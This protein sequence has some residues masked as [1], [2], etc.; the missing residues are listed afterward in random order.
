MR[1]RVIREM[2]GHVRKLV[3][4]RNAAEVLD[5]AFSAY[6]TSAE[7][8]ALAEEFY[9]P[10]YTVFKTDDAT[11]RSLRDM[12]AD[13]PTRKPSIMKHLLESLQQ[14]V[15]KGA[16]GH[17]IVHRALLDFMEN[18]DDAQVSVRCDGQWAAVCERHTDML[19]RTQEMLATLSEGWFVQVLHTHDG[20]R[21]AMHCLWRGTAKDRRAMMKS[22]KGHVPKICGDD[23][24]HWSLMAL[25]DCVDDTVLVRKYILAPM[26]DD[27][28]AL[29]QNRYARKVF[30]YLVVPRSSRYFSP[31]MVKVLEQGDGNANSKKDTDVRR[32][33]LRA[34]VSPALLDLVRARASALLRDPYG[35]HVVVET[36][37]HANDGDVA[38]AM[39]SVAQLAAG[40]VP[41]AEDNLLQHP[42]AHR[43]LKCMVAES[44]PFAAA[45]F[46]ALRPTL[47]QWAVRKASV[48]LAVALCECSDAPTAMAACQ[49]LQ[50]H[51]QLI[52]AA[53]RNSVPGLRTLCQVLWPDATAGAPD[54]RPSAPRGA[55]K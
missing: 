25:F 14:C 43:M 5:R 31:D 48:F 18:A 42:I 10:Y 40:E 27:I 38:A 16:M 4:H 2:C 22:L 3:R 24:G 26:M 46:T 20:S 19:R 47:V 7:R 15:H 41:D 51:R 12:L 23:C 1:A 49:V 32:N 13:N 53:Q 39:Q 11:R 37:L 52:M 28:E 55:S 9:G 34:A 6:A 36:L 50:Q 44:A 30:L 29:V 17:S 21:A 54:G 8:A 35:C 45:L 33:E